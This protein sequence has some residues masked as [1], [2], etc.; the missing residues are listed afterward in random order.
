VDDIHVLESF[1]SC[2][3]LSARSIKDVLSEFFAQPFAKIGTI[4][5]VSLSAMGREHDMQENAVKMLV[6]FLDIYHGLV[7][8]LAPKYAN[9]KFQSRQ[10]YPLNTIKKT[11][12]N[13]QPPDI[14]KA[15]HD[16]LRLER[17]WAYIDV[18][19]V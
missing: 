3:S 13:V 14:G 11:I 10:G 4:R 16:G 19:T 9:Y 18:D 2:E 15:L 8:T 7:D 12:L 6:A 5:E 1:A 17:K